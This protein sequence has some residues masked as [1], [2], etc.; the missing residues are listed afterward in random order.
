MTAAMNSTQTPMNVVHRSTSSMGADVA[1]P[2]PRADAAYSRMLHVSLAATAEAVGEVGADQAEDAAA[3]G[4]AAP[5]D[6]AGPLQD[7]GGPGRRID[8]LV[9]QF[10]QGR[11]GDEWHDQER[12]RVVREADDGDDQDEPDGGRQGLSA[13]APPGMGAD[14]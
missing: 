2:D 8:V 9:E 13:A 4:G 7:L 1:K 3:D 11:A 10:T 12:V 14:R 5:G 6:V